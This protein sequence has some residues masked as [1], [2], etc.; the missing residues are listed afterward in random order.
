M[1]SS[2]RR[3][4]SVEPPLKSQAD[5]SVNYVPPG[6]AGSAL[7]SVKRIAHAIPHRKI[8]RKAEPGKDELDAKHD[9]K[10]GVEVAEPGHPAEK[11]ADAVSDKVAG[12]LHDGKRDKKDEG[13]DKEAKEHESA[14]E[15]GKEEADGKE[16]GEAKEKA[17]EIGAKLEGVGLKVFLAEDGPPKLTAG[18]RKKLGNLVDMQTQTVAEAIKA[19]G[20]G[21]SQARMAGPW[22]QKT[23]AETANAAAAGDET[24]ETAIKMV[25]QASAKAGDHSGRSG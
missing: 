12:D 21:A 6:E 17:P 20:G 14:E 8:Q 24:A 2:L 13:G 7:A 25:K 19:R 11:E 5:E 22:A 9:E 3:P 4:P 1:G 23:L 15:D 18:G 10:K 16:E